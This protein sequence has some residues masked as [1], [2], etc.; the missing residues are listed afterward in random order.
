M[1][2]DYLSILSNGIIQFVLVLSLFLRKVG[3]HR[4]KQG[5]I[6]FSSIPLK[7]NLLVIVSVIYER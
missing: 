3:E 5:K 2:T 7:T 6:A 1:N 4:G